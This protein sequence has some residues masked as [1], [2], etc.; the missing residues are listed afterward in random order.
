MYKLLIVD[1]DYP[2]REWLK[3][4]IESINPNFSCE[5]ATNGADALNKVS[6]KKY[7]LVFTDIRMPEMNGLDF[8]KKVEHMGIDV[9]VVSSYQDFEYVRTAF[10]NNAVDYLLKSDINEE[11]LTAVLAKFLDSRKTSPVTP[12]PKLISQMIH[13]KNVVFTESDF[14]AANIK[15]PS[16]EFFCFLVRPEDDAGFVSNMILPADSEPEVL[17]FVQTE[18]MDFIGCAQFAHNINRNSNLNTMTRFV[19]ELINVYR[20]KLVA[21]SKIHNGFCDLKSA[22]THVYDSRMD[23]YGNGLY[24]QSEEDI[25]TA[26]MND[27]YA[28]ALDA[29]AINNY[30]NIAAAL[31]NFFDVLGTS[32]PAD[33]RSVTNRCVKLCEASYRSLN[34][35][36]GGLFSEFLDEVTAD[37]LHLKNLDALCKYVFER[38]KQMHRTSVTKPEYS[39]CINRALIFVSNNYMNQIGL[40]DV[41][42]DAGLNSQY[43]SRLFKKETGMNFVNYLNGYRLEIARNYLIE[44]NMKLYEIAENTG[45][46]TFSY[47]SKCFK[48]F[49]GKSP[50]EYRNTVKIDGLNQ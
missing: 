19:N 31:R 27:A 35:G 15:C 28:V 1:D 5:C 13:S 43:F 36:H 40:E 16:R 46:Q 25:P 4:T 39:D 7:D 42:T 17:F 44:T 6:L 14:N 32:R 48:T 29:I 3:L 23:F 20:P 41:A 26:V 10:K 38:I 11:K 8:C 30:E 47:F 45:F 12:G 18:N 49:Y 21:C 34:K 33:I 22:L 24:M 37:I 50:Y 9:V 2:I